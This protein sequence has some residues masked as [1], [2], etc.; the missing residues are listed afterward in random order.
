MV[1]FDDDQMFSF[2][3]HSWYH[4]KQQKKFKGFDKAGI[5]NMVSSYITL[6][7]KMWVE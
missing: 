3:Y 2:S 6:N 5:E 1:E 7:M 4:S